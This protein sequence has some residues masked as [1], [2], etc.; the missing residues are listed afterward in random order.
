MSAFF[1]IF[2]PAPHTEEIQ[3][4][5]IVK[6]KYHYWRIRI[7]YS[8]FIGYALFYLTR[9]SL[10]VAIR[11][12]GLSLNYDKG[13]L[14]ILASIFA[15]AYGISKF[16]SGIISD[17]AN[18]RYF[19]AFGLMMTGV[20][21]ILFGMSSS[22]T[23]FAI[24]WGLNGW[25]QGFGWPPCARYLTHWYSD[26]ERG[27][28][29]SS[30]SLSH[31]VGGML[32]PLIAG[33]CIQYFGWRYALYIP[34]VVSI[35][36][37]LFLLN[38]LRDTPQSL[39]LPPIEKFRGDDQ[40]T[41]TQADSQEEE[42]STKE[43]LI[44]FIIKNK[45]IW[46]LAAAYFFVYVVRN[47]INFWTAV[48][49]MEAKEYSRLGAN[50]C[51]SL[52]EVG[53][54]F[55]MLAAGWSSDRIFGARRGPVNVIF[56]IGMFLS[57]IAFWSIPPGH[58]IFDSAAMLLLG[59]TVFGPQMLIGVTAAELSHKKAAAT[60]T[61]FIGCF[62]YLGAAMAGYPCGIITQELGWNG[63]FFGMAVCCALSVLILIPIWGVTK[64][65]I[66]QSAKPKK[67]VPTDAEY[68]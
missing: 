29:W 27:A 33:A 38:R 47:G 4:Q 51:V 15:I 3:D 65:S 54:F 22:L 60:S 16:A 57:V 53:G 23:F 42:L 68:A 10:N 55:G 46:L 19:M 18:P 61:G 20:F 45:Y 41:N 58:P 64:K 59:F 11:D 8:S 31:N 5:E 49:L 34:G 50:G 13:Q 40:E 30:W 1:N 21:N 37:G 35:L 36:G 32:T 39:G 26:S 28:W 48:Y 43:I 66:S 63:Y 17:R 9:L 62:A 2:R 44:N 52:F 56:C 25:F 67:Q 24:F 7:M 12:L 14:G 6:E